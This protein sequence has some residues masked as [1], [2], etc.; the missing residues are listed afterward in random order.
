MIR[1]QIREPIWKTRSIGLAEDRLTNITEVEITYKNRFG[2]RIYANLYC[3]SKS[4]AM[5]YP[6]QKVK[7]VKLRIIPIADLQ[8]WSY[9]NEEYR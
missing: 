4:Q 5:K 6:I 3:I 7:G 1:I 8:A 2:E 9:S